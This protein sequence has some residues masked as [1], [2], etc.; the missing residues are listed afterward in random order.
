[1]SNDRDDAQGRQQPD[2]SGTEGAQH[3]AEDTGAV[4]R[5]G[6]DD[7]PAAGA[8]AAAAG[9]TAAGPHSSWASPEQDQ[10]SWGTPQHGSGTG[11]QTPPYGQQPPYDQQSYGQ[12]YG[13]PYG[14]AP[15]YGQSPY[16]Q[17]PWGQAP[18]GQGPQYGQSPYGQPVAH[19]GPGQPAVPG[20]PGTVITSAVLGLLYGVLGLLTALLFVIGGAYADDFLDAV[21][22]TDPSLEGTLGS[23]EVDGFRAVLVVFGVVALVWAVV[24][25]WGSFLALRGRSRVLLLV[26][27]WI[28]V[29]VTAVLLL[30]AV[31]GAATA[32]EG[33]GAGGIV[34]FLLLFLGTVAMAVLLLLRPSAAYFAIHRQRRALAPR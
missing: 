11:V 16:G 19:G 24:M 2:P 23:S 22:D 7:A 1:M 6:V 10:G 15:Q 34:L 27:A 4:D 33:G 31:V 12:Q 20:R 14:Q 29:A 5:G 3:P 28:A 26:G 32:P 13:S 25:V 21:E 8:T 9:A 18:Y 17:A 30:L